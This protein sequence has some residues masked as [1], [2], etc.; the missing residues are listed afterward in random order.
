MIVF[1]IN[2]ISELPQN[3][4]LA[5]IEPQISLLNQLSVVL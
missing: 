4:V 1:R 2:L 5:L 3:V